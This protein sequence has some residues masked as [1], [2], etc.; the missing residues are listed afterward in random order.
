MTILTTAYN[1]EKFVEKCLYSIM[2]QQFKDFHC[3]IFDDVS[4][5]NSN[6]IISEVIKDDK[7]FTLI[8]NENKLYQPGNYDLVIRKMNLSDDEICVEV[9]GKCLT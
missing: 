9:D 7:R 3:Y 6:K 4:T 8:S 5:D 2:S 1:C